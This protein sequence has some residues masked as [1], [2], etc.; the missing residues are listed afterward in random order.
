[1]RYHVRGT[2]RYPNDIN[3]FGYISEE[4]TLCC[5]GAFSEI[6][7]GDEVI[8]RKYAPPKKE[9]SQTAG[10]RRV[11]QGRKTAHARKRTS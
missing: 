4:L 3:K 7:V 2:I 1:M 10:N 11:T 5:F 8:V 6:E 9:R